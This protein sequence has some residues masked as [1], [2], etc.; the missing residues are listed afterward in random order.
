VKKSTKKFLKNKLKDE[1]ARR[2]QFKKDN[3]HRKVGP[4]GKGAEEKDVADV[5]DPQVA[6]LED[7]SDD[8]AGFVLDEDVK[9]LSKDDLDADD[10]DEDGDDIDDLENYDDFE[11]EEGEDDDEDLEGEQDLDDDALD[12][13]TDDGDNEDDPSKRK[14]RHLRDEIAEHKKQLEEA[15]KKDPVFFKFLKEN[16]MDLLNFGEGEDDEGDDDAVDDEEEPEDLQNIMK[17]EDQDEDDGENDGDEQE[18]EGEDEEMESDVEIPEVTKVMITSWRKNL[19][20]KHSLRSAK[21][22]LLALKAA[23][24]QGET[25][26]DENEVQSYRIESKTVHNLVLLTALKH[27]IPTFNEHLPVKETKS[28]GLPSSS[29]KWKAVAPFVKSFLKSLLKMLEHTSDE[30]MLRF[31][32]RESEHSGIYFACFPKLAKEYLKNL[33]RLW[34]TTKPETRISAFLALRRL[35]VSCPSPYLDFAIKGAYKTFATASRTTNVHTWSSI[36]FMI[37]CIVE[38]CGIDITTTYYFAFVYIRQLA[39]LLRNAITMKS[40][41]SF[42]SVYN[43]QFIHCLRAW[44]KVLSTYCEKG[45]SAEATGGSALKPLIYPL[46]QVTLGAMRLKPSSKFFPLRFQAV[47]LLIE[48]SRKTSTY[49]PLSSHL[50][51]VFES[52]ELRSKPK[53]S[54]LKPMDF[55]LALK[56]PNQYLGTRPYQVGVAEEAVNLLIDFYDCFALSVGFP[57]L[58]VPAVLQF[59]RYMKKSKN[60]IAN[61]QIQ[62]LLEVLEQNSKFIEQKRANVDFAPKDEGKATAFSENLDPT[63]SPLRKHALSRRKLREQRSAEMMA[64]A[65]KMATTKGAAGAQLK[66][67]KA[68]KRSRGKEQERV[69]ED[70]EDGGDGDGEERGEDDDEVGD[71]VMSDEDEDEDDGEGELEW[72]GE[73]MEVDDEE[74]M[75]EEDD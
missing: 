7:E 6:T 67:V 35:A 43:W 15:M 49:I 73:E 30:S 8:D 34:T 53:P 24:A 28:R 38:L 1:V 32:L 19:T 66:K 12:A 14:R 22:V 57:E 2:R 72:E 31:I 71:F 70:S 26:S 60:V 4:K 59:K 69:D 44:S 48:L 74:E 18:M 55:G 41:D 3:K 33:L 23:I 39:I 13:Q 65:A 17:G 36:N 64:Q 56:T 37:S 61:K 16:D 27:I 50:F 47:R 75:E 9:G 46:V 54:T 20:A 52:S 42:K 5:D 25:E 11:D 45:S 68:V 21:K 40:K 10:D 51:E 63:Q 62:Q 58:A 29:K